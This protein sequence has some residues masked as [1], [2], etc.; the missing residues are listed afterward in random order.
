V[1]LIPYLHFNGQ[2]EQA[3]GFSEKCLGAKIVVLMTYGTSPMATQA[4]PGWQEKM[5][6]ATL[7]LGDQM[8]QGADAFP[9]H[10]Q[11]PQ[12][13]AISLN[14]QAAA[15]ADRI[16][17]ALAANGTVQLALQETFWALRFG[18]LVDQFGTP[19]MINCQPNRDLKN[20]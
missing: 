15:D 20:P 1:R 14:I 19:W 12:G 11:K 2:C 5:V 10:Y 18:M 9:E 7:A 13:F 8:L 6:H 3:F 16:F 17:S 4:P